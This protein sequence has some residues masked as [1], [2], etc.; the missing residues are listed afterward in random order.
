[1][2]IHR[3]RI[4]CAVDPEQW[5]EAPGGRLVRGVSVVMA[6]EPGE[7]AP[8]ERISREPSAHVLTPDEARALAFE[9]LEAAEL[10]ERE[11]AAD[12]R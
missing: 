1:M 6:D 4:L 7:G 2:T 10:C 12:E 8:S 3:D 5:L 9:L 11:E